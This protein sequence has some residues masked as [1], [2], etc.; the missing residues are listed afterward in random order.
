MEKIKSI[1]LRNSVWLV[2]MAVSLL[3]L[4]PAAAEFNTILLILLFECIALSLSGVSAYVFTKIDFTQSNALS[5]LGYI[6]LGVHICV[7]LI[8]L[9]VYIAQYAN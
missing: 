3:L 8:V 1:I 9:G 5:N 7:G 2:I 4:K 6:F